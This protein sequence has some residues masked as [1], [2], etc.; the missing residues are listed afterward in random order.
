[1]TVGASRMIG[2]PLFPHSSLSS[3]FRRAST[4]PNPIRF[5]MLYSHLF[6]CLPFL[7]PP[8]T[9]PCRII[10]G[11]PVDLVMCPTHLNMRFLTMV[12]R[13]SY[14]PIACLILFPHFFIRNMM[15][16]G[17]AQKFSK[18]SHFYSMYLSLYSAVRVHVSHAHRKIELTKERTNLI[19]ELRA[20]FLSF[21]NY[22]LEL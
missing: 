18:A 16:G 5:G 9:V 3:A 11:S 22:G 17:D 20:M 6:F 14:G 4:N 7:L 1:M 2:Q 12:I 15:F 21:D 10:C 8:C 13:S 19:S